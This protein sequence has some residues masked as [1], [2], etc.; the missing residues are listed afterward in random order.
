MTLPQNVR[1]FFI[2]IKLK[3]NNN[4]FTDLI[5]CKKNYEKYFKKLA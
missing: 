2:S 1:V 5:G 3:K 4:K